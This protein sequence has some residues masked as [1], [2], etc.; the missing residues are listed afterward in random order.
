MQTCSLPSGMERK[1]IG[2]G[3]RLTAVM[4]HKDADSAQIDIRK[5]SGAFVLIYIVLAV[6]FYILAGRQLHVRASKSNIAMPA[7]NSATVELARQSSVEQV[8]TSKIQRLQSISILWGTYY[9]AN[10]GTVLVEL[11][12][13]AGNKRLMQQTLS[14]ADITEGFVSTMASEEP[15]EG[16]Y[17]T[18]LLLRITADAEP[19]SAPSPLMNADASG[20]GFQLY[21]NA[22]PAKGMLCF[23]AQGED[24][25]WTGLHYWEIA[26]CGLGLLLLYLFITK[27]KFKAGKASLFVIAL[28]AFKKYRFLIKQLIARDFKAKYKRSIL[29]VLWSFLNPLLTMSV[30]YIVFSNLFRFNVAYY[31][32][33]LLCGI[34]LFNYFS[35][36]CGMALISIV[37]NA[38]LITKVY[39]PKYIYP[40]TRVISS[41]INLLIA[42]IPLIIVALIS[43]LHIT[44]AY[45][46]L[47]FVLIC[48][49]VFCFGLGMLLASAMVFFR[50]TQ[51]LWGVLSMIWMYLTPIFYPESIVPAS[52]AAVLKLNPL[53]YFINFAR[54]CVIGGV[55]PEPL[56]YVKCVCF[57][58]SMMLVG[59][60][61]F[62]RAQDRF[63][64]YL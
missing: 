31:P 11:Y 28:T 23:S 44:K 14:A 1:L 59:A 6:A 5:V 47:P 56:V 18:P 20:E 36:S 17:L 21:L 27:R 50:D 61:V 10:A 43:G 34:V 39:M 40:F 38:S 55:S 57:A 41:F 54:T 12:E 45:L 30:Q 13:L 19:G 33:Y 63:V 4:D 22:A 48:L 49:A 29:G 53:Y 51:F 16:L 8:F 24:Y 60:Y 25:I 26:G 3:E 64:L 42:L 15:L 7:A 32:V 37:G 52:V 62:K 58:L 46:L 2:S 9:R 35:E